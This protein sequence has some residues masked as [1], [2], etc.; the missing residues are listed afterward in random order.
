MREGF[1]A[2]T[3]NR[4]KFLGGDNPGYALKYIE[5]D[6]P[7]SGLEVLMV[8][9]VDGVD[10]AHIIAHFDEDWLGINNSIY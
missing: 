4:K 3:N 2:I 6:L 7:P 8:R 10:L 1:D 9:V 5:T